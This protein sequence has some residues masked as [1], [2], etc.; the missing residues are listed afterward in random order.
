MTTTIFL[1]FIIVLFWLCYK[2]SRW[3]HRGSYL[4]FTVVLIASS[5]GVPGK[6]VSNR[7]EVMVNPYYIIPSQSS[8]SRFKPTIYDEQGSGNNWIYAE[9][10]KNYYYAGSFA[11]NIGS[12]YVFV[13][14]DVELT[15]NGFKVHDFR[16]W[17][18]NDN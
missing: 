8:L 7:L 2:I 10:D 6:Y 18:I 3:P 15:C 16:T 14:R 1:V 4:T 12:G 17:C 5:Y 13:S 11:Q 9:D